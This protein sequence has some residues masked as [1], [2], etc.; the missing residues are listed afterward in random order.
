MQLFSGGK[1][2][3]TGL[4]ASKKVKGPI[5]ND[6]DTR[7]QIGIL[8]GGGY[9]GLSDE[10]SQMA[11]QR[12]RDLVGVKKAQDLVSHIVIQNSR[13]DFQK[14]APAERVS[15]FYDVNSSNPDTHSLVQKMKSIG[16]GVLPGYQQ[17]A[18]LPAQKQQGY[19]EPSIIGSIA[20]YTQK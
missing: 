6:V 17:S 11:F 1:G 5:D 3:K 13:P 12:L 19:K 8:V 14:M 4:V 7:D 15:R 20:S 16:T 10:T 9:K 18:Y 2:E